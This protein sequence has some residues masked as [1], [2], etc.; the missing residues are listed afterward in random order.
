MNKPVCLSILDIK[1][2][3]MYNYCNDYAKPKYGTW[4]H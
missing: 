1:K 3:A 4:Q 2:T